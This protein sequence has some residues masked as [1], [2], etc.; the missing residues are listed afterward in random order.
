MNFPIE[1]Y[2][3]VEIET[4]FIKIEKGFAQTGDNPDSGVTGNGFSEG[5]VF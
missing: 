4:T 5:D 2:E 1:T 3:S